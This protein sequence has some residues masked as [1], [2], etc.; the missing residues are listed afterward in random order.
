MIYSSPQQARE[1]LLECHSR[2][3]SHHHFQLWNCIPS[4]PL[5]SCP[6]S[7]LPSLPPSCP[8]FLLL[9]LLDIHTRLSRDPPG[10]LPGRVPKPLLQQERVLPHDVLRHSILE[11]RWSLP[12]SRENCCWKVYL[13]PL[14][15][16]FSL[17][18]PSPS[19]ISSLSLSHSLLYPSVPFSLPSLSPL[20][21]LS[22]HSPSP[23]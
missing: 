1:V 3:R 8:S 6:P 12:V 17:R 2:G 14:P 19:S 5:P 16:L 22:R 20:S 18:P 13:T 15:H 7:L 23:Y 4:S 11:E 21:P 10:D 9:F